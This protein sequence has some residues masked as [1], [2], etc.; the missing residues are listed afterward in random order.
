M[1][2]GERSAEVQVFLCGARSGEEARRTARLLVQEGLRRW[3][4]PH[5]FVRIEKNSQGRPF[6]SCGADVPQSSVFPDISLSHAPGLSAVALGW[7]C[8]VG[9]D[10]EP[11][12]TLFPPPMCARLFTPAEMA[13]PLADPVR[14]WTRKE[15]VLKGDGRGLCVDLSQ[16]EALQDSV[17]L[18]GVIWHWHDIS[19]G[20]EHVC[21][22]AVDRP[23]P[24]REA[25]L[26][27]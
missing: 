2:A 13:H 22:L 7:G 21:C 9:V 3:D 12:S 15:S 23:A 17:E 5:A 20:P 27:L 26:H 19:A 10:V 24:V 16:L 4:L 18:D 11:V 14:L 6:L 8:R 25:A 1:S